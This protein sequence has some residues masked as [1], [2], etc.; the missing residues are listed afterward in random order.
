M[1][2]WMWIVIGIAVVFALVLLLRRP[3]SRS[4]RPVVG[5]RRRF[6]G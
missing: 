1:T 5:R 3:A 2:T 6:L 4:R